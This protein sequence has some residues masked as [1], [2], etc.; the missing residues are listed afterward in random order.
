[1]HATDVAPQLLTTTETAILEAI[2]SLH[3]GSVEITIH[4]SKIVQVECTRKIRFGSN[5]PLEASPK[6]AGKIG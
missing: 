1:L 3:F 5:G 2:R 6:T 4:D